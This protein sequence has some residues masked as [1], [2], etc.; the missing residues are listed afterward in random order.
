MSEKITPLKT[1]ASSGDG[2]FELVP[3]G[4][5][6]A[7]CFKM[8]DLGTQDTMYLGKPS[9]KK[10]KIQLY[11]ELLQDEEGNPVFMED[12]ERVFS[13]SKEY[14]WSLGKNANLLAD[15]NSW[16]GVDLTKEEAADFEISKLLGVCCKLQVMHKKSKDGQKTFANVGAIMTTTKKADGV[17]PLASFSIEDPDMALFETFS[18]YLQDKIR[19]ADEWKLEGEMAT[20]SISEDGN[21]VIDDLANDAPVITKEELGKLPF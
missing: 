15:L 3:A 19:M 1:P 9:G 10:R 2:E 14:T 18:A 12:G 8:I 5:Y 4:V 7:R 11:W 21:I 6:L 13:I 20:G 17:N 16:R